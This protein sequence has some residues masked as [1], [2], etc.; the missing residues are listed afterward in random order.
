MSATVSNDVTA[1]MGCVESSTKGERR[2]SESVDKGASLNDVVVESCASA[3]QREPSIPRDG[4]RHDEL[5]TADE[6][7]VLDADWARLSRV[8]HQ[9]LGMRVFL[10]I[11]ELEPS[12]KSSFPEL[13]DLDGDELVANT[14]FRCHGARFMRAVA[15]QRASCAPSRPPSTTSTRSTSSSFRTSSNSAAFTTPSPGLAGDT[16]APSN[17]PWPRSAARR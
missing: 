6:R 1:E 14:L 2:R 12:T 7:A 9:Q 5:L 11:F 8:D 10:R 16:C 13:C 17:E 3:H 4:A 15:A